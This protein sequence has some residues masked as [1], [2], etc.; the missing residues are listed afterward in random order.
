MPLLM[1][2]TWLVQEREAMQAQLTAL[3]DQPEL[4]KNC[5]QALAASERYSADYVADIWEKILYRTSE[6]ENKV[7]Q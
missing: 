2:I 5:Q 4:Q 3:H 7:S 1:V 6:L